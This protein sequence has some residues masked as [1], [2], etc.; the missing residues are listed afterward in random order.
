MRRILAI[1]LSICLL[2]TAVKA[3]SQTKYV[4]LTFDDGPSGRFTRRL[5][6][7]LQQRQVPATFF[8][9][10]YRIKDYPQLT[11]RIFEEGHEI[12]LHGYSHNNMGQMTAREVTGEIEATQALLPEGCRP[13]FLRPPGGICADA[14]LQAAREADLS[15]LLWSV[16]PKDW[17]V[18]DAPTVTAAVIDRV[19]SGDVILLHDMTDSSVDAA[20]AIIDRLQEQGFTFVTVSQL[21]SLQ[22]Y[23]LQPGQVYEQ[24]R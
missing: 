13:V 3:D 18:L 11:Q 1:L 17:K 6:D 24:F 5:L 15:L 16:D 2:C 22:G 23:D 4:A 20:L 7:G 19:K 8:L 12:C 14:V 9:C 21:A 10:G